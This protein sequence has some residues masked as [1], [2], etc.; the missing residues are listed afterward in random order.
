M[1]DPRPVERRNVQRQLAIFD[2]VRHARGKSM[3]EI[4]QLLREA[5]GRRRLT[6]PSD[7]WLDAVAT[8]AA[9]GKPYLV[10]LP[11]AVAADSVMEAPDPTVEETLRL[12]RQLR[13]SEAGM[14]AAFRRSAGAGKPAGRTAG[15]D[16]GAASGTNNIGTVRRIATVAI[17][18]TL[19]ITAIEIIR[20][21]GQRRS[22]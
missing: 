18:A 20:A 7:S 19:A 16:G 22:R 13:A 5:F 3:A 1:D 17:A 10:D 11:A 8:E 14:A 4:K 21:V 2:V 12:R 9:Y 15:S 6:I